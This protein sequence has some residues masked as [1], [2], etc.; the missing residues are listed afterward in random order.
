MNQRINW[1]VISQSTGYKSL[2]EAYVRDLMSKR[3]GRSKAE[4]RSVFRFAIGRA[5][6]IAHHTNLPLEEILKQLEADR[7]YWWLGYYTEGKIPKIH[8]NVL[9][10]RGINYLRKDYKK[11]GSL[12]N[13]KYYP[14][15]RICDFIIHN[16]PKRTKK[17][18]WTK[19]MKELRD[20]Y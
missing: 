20:R 2:K 9:K 13:R 1:K 19:R 6:H 16:Q 8:P 3:S 4:L 14:N 12:S 7:S 10:P 18:R 5:M 15:R 17:A 11:W